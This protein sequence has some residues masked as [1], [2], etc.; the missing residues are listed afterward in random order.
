MTR[1]ARCSHFYA[2]CQGGSAGWM[3][4]LRSLLVRLNCCAPQDGGGGRRSEEPDD[5]REEQ[6]ADLLALQQWAPATLALAACWKAVA[7]DEPSGEGE[8]DYERH[9]LLRI[10]VTGGNAA[11]CAAAANLAW[12]DPA[13]DAT[14]ELLLIVAVVFTEGGRLARL[15]MDAAKLAWLCGVGGCCIGSSA[16]A[17]PF[18]GELTPIPEYVLLASPALMKSFGGGSV[19]AALC[20]FDAINGRVAAAT[21]QRLHITPLAAPSLLEFVLGDVRS[22]EDVLGTRA[23]KHLLAA[24]A[25]AGSVRAVAP[26][27]LAS[28]EPAPVVTQ[29]EIAHSESPLPAAL[30]TALYRCL[31]G[32]R[33]GGLLDTTDLQAIFAG[34]GLLLRVYGPQPPHGHC[35]LHA[36]FEAGVL[37][38]SDVVLALLDEGKQVGKP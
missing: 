38:D 12:P 19:D 37:A 22:V 31:H 23:L 26:S 10:A 14:Q 30:R 16:Q 33:E 27:S 29:I 6:F 21:G 24:L 18:Y 25:G 2:L 3:D 5:A 4:R 35:F 1:F 15:Y 17:D 13:T 9:Q 36:L 11:V 7:R 8:G 34:S 28:V 20:E 32:R